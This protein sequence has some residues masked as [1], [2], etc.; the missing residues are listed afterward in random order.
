MA[1]IVDGILL[2]FIDVTSSGINIHQPI[3]NTDEFN[4]ENNDL[5]SLVIHSL[6]SQQSLT[7]FDVGLN[8]LSS[9]LSQR[10]LSKDMCH[11]MAHNVTELSHSLINEIKVTHK[12]DLVVVFE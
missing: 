8:N 9:L 3:I 2:K 1:F 5:K 10:T 11:F 4:T 7:K 6:S 12:E